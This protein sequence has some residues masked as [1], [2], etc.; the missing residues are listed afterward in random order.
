MR[1]ELHDLRLLK[2]AA[3][4]EEAYERFVVEVADRVVEDPALRARLSRLVD[5]RDRHAERIAAATR[6]LER[7]LGPADRAG[8]VRAALMDVCDVE[9]AARDFYR[10]MA[11]RVHDGEVAGLFRALAGEEDAHLRIAE[12]VLRDAERQAGADARHDAAVA[13]AFRLLGEPPDLPL[14]EGVTD[15][16]QHHVPR[17]KHA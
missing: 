15:F 6:R 14:R 11:D 2:L 1:A 10:G 17:R 5:P 4:Y 9:R 8:A 12:G 16:G 3:M 13:E 7:T